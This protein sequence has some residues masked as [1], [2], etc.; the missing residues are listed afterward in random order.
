MDYSFSGISM[1][2][3]RPD[4]RDPGQIAA[5]RHIESSNRLTRRRHEAHAWSKVGDR[6]DKRR[7]C[8]T[9]RRHRL[10]PCRH[11]ITIEPMM[12]EIKRDLTAGQRSALRF[13]CV[14]CSTAISERER[15][16][17][18]V[19]DCQKA[20]GPVTCV[21]LCWCGHGPSCRQRHGGAWHPLTRF[22]SQSVTTTRG[23]R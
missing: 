19:R 14:V 5:D 2:R 4:R 16:A 20:P 10:P 15:L 7:S 6:P 18:G 17:E 21:A 12:L 3:A 23:R 1:A 22:L 9:W 8:A 13:P 11:S